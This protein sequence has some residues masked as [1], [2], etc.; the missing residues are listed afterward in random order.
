MYQ[1]LQLLNLSL[2]KVRHLNEM[3]TSS[4]VQSIQHSTLRFP[5]N[6]P[7]AKFPLFNQGHS[8]ILFK[9]TLLAAG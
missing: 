3:L 4:I 1:I 2:D 6:T 9:S 5:Y 8:S 7:H